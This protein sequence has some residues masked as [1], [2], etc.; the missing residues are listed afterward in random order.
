MCCQYVHTL[1]KLNKISP[2]DNQLCRKQCPSIIHYQKILVL[3]WERIKHTS[4]WESVTLKSRFQGKRNLDASPNTSVETYMSF[5]NACAAKF[6]ALKNDPYDLK[7]GLNAKT[8][9]T[10]LYVSF[11][12]SCFQPLPI[13]MPT[14]LEKQ[15]QEKNHKKE[16]PNTQEILINL[17]KEINDII[18]STW[19]EAASGSS[20]P[21]A[22]LN[23]IIIS[24]S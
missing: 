1:E 13:N 14:N 24:T 16:T 12:I 6:N 11:T 19:T 8:Y 17:N 3:I 2:L 23:L 9:P 21:R 15:R 4:T 18:T 7:K 20:M 5:W 22:S 10:L